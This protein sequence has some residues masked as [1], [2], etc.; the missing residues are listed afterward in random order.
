LTVDRIVNGKL[1]STKISG[2]TGA[3][4]AQQNAESGTILGINS[5]EYNV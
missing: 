4:V 5:I 1:T 2:H 3:T